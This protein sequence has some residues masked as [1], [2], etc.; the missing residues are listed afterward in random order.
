M[1]NIGLKTKLGGNLRRRTAFKQKI[2]IEKNFLTFKNL[3]KN[4]FLYIFAGVL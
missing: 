3:C 1:A 4:L 2:A